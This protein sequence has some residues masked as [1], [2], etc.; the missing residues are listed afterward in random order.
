[1]HRD[2]GRLRA[3]PLIAPMPVRSCFERYRFGVT[4]EHREGGM[5]MPARVRSFPRGPLADQAVGGDDV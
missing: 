5:G 4:T 2:G 1:M 3:E